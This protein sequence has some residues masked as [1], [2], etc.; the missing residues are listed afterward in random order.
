[1][2]TVGFGFEP[3]S[4]GRTP[5]AR[6]ASSLLCVVT[7]GSGR[8]GT[9]G[10]PLLPAGGDNHYAMAD[11]FLAPGDVEDAL[12]VAHMP[13][14][15]GRSGVHVQMDFRVRLHLGHQAGQVKLH[16]GPLE[17]GVES[18]QIAAQGGVLSTR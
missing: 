14:D 7:W 6:A 1:M 18:A 5:P 10:R 13:G 3:S 16:I 11:G 12:E 9:R 17:R 4:G 8:G 15:A 2:T